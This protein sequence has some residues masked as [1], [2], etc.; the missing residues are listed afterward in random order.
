MVDQTTIGTI[1]SILRNTFA[2]GPPKTV[3]NQDL[4]NL[5]QKT[6][7][8]YLEFKMSKRQCLSRHCTFIYSFENEA[9][10]CAYGRE[11]SQSVSERNFAKKM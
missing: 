6:F 2:K 8:T 10:E 7:N 11:L 4:V 3:Y 5:D 1:F 9:G